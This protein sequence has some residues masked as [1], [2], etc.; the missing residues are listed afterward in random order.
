MA[1]KKK[2]K[3]STRKK[4]HADNSNRK[5]KGIKDILEFLQGDNLI[6]EESDPESSGKSRKGD[7][8]LTFKRRK[9]PISVERKESLPTQGLED[10]KD[11]AKI[12]L[13]R[14][15]YDEWKVYTDLNTLLNLML[16]N[17]S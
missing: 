12:L 11:D 5:Q 17:R 8:T 2:S 3:K 10:S 4:K 9:Y 13:Y 7:L 1:K 14:K 16:N 15:N 6:V